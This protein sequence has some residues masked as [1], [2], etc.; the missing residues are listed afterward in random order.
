[1]KRLVTSTEIESVVKKLPKNKSPGPDGFT[2]EF[3]RIFRVKKIAEEATLPNSFYDT[4]NTLIL[5]SEKI[6][7]KKDNYRPI[8]VMKIDAK[9]FNKIPANQ[10]QQ[11]IKR[12][13]HHDQVRYILG[14]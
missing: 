12:I 5:K 14:K 11:Y 4:N 6:Y 1:M 8:F 9:I 7:H 13:I 10:I 2:D 3:Y